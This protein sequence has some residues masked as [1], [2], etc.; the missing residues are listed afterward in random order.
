MYECVLVGASS[1]TCFDAVLGHVPD[2]LQEPV[3]WLARCSQLQVQQLSQ[4]LW[5]F[6]ITN[7][8]QKKTAVFR[9]PKIN[10]DTNAT[11]KTFC[12][13]SVP[14]LSTSSTIILKA[15]VRKSCPS[16]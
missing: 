14:L 9:I 13:T 2:S 7:L 5:F 15:S 16:E 1:G 6:P 8:H 11:R 12:W 10:S 4:L 3:M